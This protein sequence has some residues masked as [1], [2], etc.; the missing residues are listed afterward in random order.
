MVLEIRCIRSNWCFIPA[1]ESSLQ[2][3]A[4]SCSGSEGKSPPYTV[5]QEYE[6]A[7]DAHLISDT[8]GLVLFWG[9]FFYF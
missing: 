8:F 4:M 1:C 7:Q 9:P 2:L 6:A 3:Q 5:T